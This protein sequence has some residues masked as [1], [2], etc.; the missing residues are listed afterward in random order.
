M[1]VILHLS[2]SAFHQSVFILQWVK[3]QNAFKPLKPTVAEIASSS[4]SHCSREAGSTLQTSL[5]C[6]FVPPYDILQWNL[7][8]HFGVEMLWFSWDLTWMQWVHLAESSSGGTPEIQGERRASYVRGC[9]PEAAFR[10]PKL[11]RWPSQWSRLPQGPPLH[12]S[13][14]PKYKKCK[15][16]QACDKTSWMASVEGD[17]EGDLWTIMN[18]N[19]NSTP[20]SWICC[21]LVSSWAVAL[22]QRAPVEAN[23]LNL[24]ESNKRIRNIQKKWCCFA[25]NVKGDDRILDASGPWIHLE[26]SRGVRQSFAAALCPHPWDGCLIHPRGQI[27]SLDYHHT[28][29]IDPRQ[30]TGPQR[31]TSMFIIYHTQQE[32][33]RYNTS[34]IVGQRDLKQSRTNDI[35]SSEM[36]WGEQILPT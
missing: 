32:W 18:P 17:T 16:K 29:I 25:G 11:R 26:C 1:L 2:A 6:R 28:T 5:N 9:P 30:Y 7:T 19:K 14:A 36:L 8:A 24:S 12:I 34:M 35:F 10:R 20:R 23:Q 13:L 21:P 31:H 22:I 3:L 15:E 4:R 27:S 33:C